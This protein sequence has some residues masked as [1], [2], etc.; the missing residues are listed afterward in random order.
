MDTGVISAAFGAL[1]QERRFEVIA[2]NLANSATAG[3]KRDRISFADLLHPPGAAAPKPLPEPS[4]GGPALIP[5]GIGRS[6]EA[7]R[8]R[9][10]DVA[11]DL[12]QGE[13]QET[14][15]PLDLA[16]EGN[17]FF[18]L[19]TPQ[20]VLYTRRGSFGLGKDGILVSQEGYPVLGA[21]GQKIVAR[22][23]SLTVS[24]DG[25][26]SAAGEQVG[27]LE[28]AQFPE[29]AALE[30]AGDSLFAAA[31][32]PGEARLP[33][34]IRQGALEMSNVNA[35]SEMVEM[36]EALRQYEAYQK[37]LQAYGQIDA[38]SVEVAELR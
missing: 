26:V 13:I 20:G 37:V 12:D 21:G 9:V 8:V 7:S 3:F 24:R 14:G 31:G 23:G 17:G 18:K 4:E 34:G 25:T 11:A 35:I 27:R 38:R 29:G 1:T 6:W 36:I 33:Y 15:N 22:A 30:K 16:I 2:N 28:V 19:K 32:D 10:T 5:V